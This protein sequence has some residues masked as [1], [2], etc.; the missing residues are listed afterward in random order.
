MLFFFLHH[1]TF[2]WSSAGLPF[3]LI[4]TVDFSDCPGKWGLPQYLLTQLLNCL[5]LGCI[6]DQGLYQ[7]LCD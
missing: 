2:F 5:K 1:C 3:Y 7:K 6:L 4:F